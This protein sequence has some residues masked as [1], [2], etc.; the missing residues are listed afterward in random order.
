MIQKFEMELRPHIARFSPNIIPINKTA[1]FPFCMLR[2]KYTK[3]EQG[4]PLTS[5]RE[6]T[7]I[8]SGPHMFWNR[9]RLRAVPD[10]GPAGAV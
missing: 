7:I 10:G 3:S 2:E 5:H 8:N 1:V 9:D 6:T 4:N